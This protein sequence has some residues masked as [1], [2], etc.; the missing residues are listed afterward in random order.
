[1]GSEYADLLEATG[2][3]TVVELAKRNP[4][5]LLN[6]VLETNKVKQLVS[7]EPAASQ[8]EDWV[9]QARKLPRVIEY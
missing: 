1:V 7:K 3:D 5:K 8:V 9:A 2:V 6:A 4:A